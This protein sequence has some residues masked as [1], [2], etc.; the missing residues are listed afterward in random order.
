MFVAVGAAST[1]V[2]TVPADNTI[3]AVAHAK[4]VKKT[5]I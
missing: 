1:S 2:D 3:D 5:K 4:P